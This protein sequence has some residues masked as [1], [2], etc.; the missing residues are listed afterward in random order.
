MLLVKGA[1]SAIGSVCLVIASHPK[2]AV[3]V[4][5]INEKIILGIICFF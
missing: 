4:N 3:R 2:L 5:K 1:L